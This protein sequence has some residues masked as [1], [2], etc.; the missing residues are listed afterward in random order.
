M[1]GNMGVHQ[2]RLATLFISVD[3]NNAI[4]SKIL[5]VD[6]FYKEIKLE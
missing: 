1:P 5:M 6:I 2:Q 3:S 4:N